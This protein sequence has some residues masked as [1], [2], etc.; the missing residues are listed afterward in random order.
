MITSTLVIVALVAA[1]AAMS[2][3]SAKSSAKAQKNAAEYSAAVER[4]AAMTAQQQAEFDAQQIRDK[5]RRLVASQRAAFAASGIDPNSGR[6]T[7]VSADTKNQ[8]EMEALIAIYTGRSS[9][10]GHL[11]QS[12]LDTMRGDA[13]H[14]AGNI[15]AASSLLSG[16]SSASTTKSSGNPGF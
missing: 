2:A 12:R 15:N 6:A 11:A 14:R 7:D 1:S 5:S 9:A 16:A 3:A 10:T 8:G 4:N 13:A